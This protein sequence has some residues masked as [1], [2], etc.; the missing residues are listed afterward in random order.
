[1][2]ENRIKQAGQSTNT[3]FAMWFAWKGRS[4]SKQSQPKILWKFDLISF[5]SAFVCSL[6]D[7][8]RSQLPASATQLTVCN[9]QEFIRLKYPQIN[10]WCPV[11]P[12]SGRLASQSSSQLLP[13]FLSMRRPNW[14]DLINF[15]V[16]VLVASTTTRDQRFSAEKK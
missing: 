10:S 14:V 4:T 7:C 9:H 2:C 13:F 1:M 5:P 15:A 16:C 3:Q 6:I 8:R 11:A 12:P